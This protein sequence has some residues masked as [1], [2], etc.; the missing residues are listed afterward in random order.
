MGT[1]DVVRAVG[2]RWVS[3][4]L[5]SDSIVDFDIAFIRFYNEYYQGS[6]TPWHCRAKVLSG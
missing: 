6:K 1:R 2:I 5:K 3:F 4:V